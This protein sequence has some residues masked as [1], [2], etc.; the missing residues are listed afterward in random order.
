MLSW[1][2]R[3]GEVTSIKEFEAAVAKVTKLKP[4]NVLFGEGVGAVRIGPTCAP[5]PFT[6]LGTDKFSSNNHP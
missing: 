5:S 3:P 4:V 6:A 2:R 1:L